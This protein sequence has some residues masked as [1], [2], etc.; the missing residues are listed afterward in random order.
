M[1]RLVLFDLDDTLL[2]GDSDFEWGQYLIEQGALDRGI[3]E[4]RNR[5]FYEQYKAG[6]LDIQTFLD[7]QLQPYAQFPKSQLEA[8]RAS[9]LTEKVL[10]LVRPGAHRLVARHAGDVVAIITATNRFITGPIAEALGISTLLATELEEVDGRFTGRAAGTPCF[11]EGKV[12]R[13]EE[14]LADRG[15]R[16]GDYAESWFYSDSINDVPLLSAVSNPVAV[17]PDDKLRAHA[18]KQGWPILLLDSSEVRFEQQSGS[19]RRP[20]HV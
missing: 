10:P 2:S 18:T 15:E 17:H 6:V 14:W 1:K 16:L 20:A 5:E 12:K 19:R 9:Y 7:F 4:T 13:L 11:R 8:W 3:Y